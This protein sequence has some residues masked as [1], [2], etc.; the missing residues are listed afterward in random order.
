[1]LISIVTE[2]KDSQ[3]VASLVVTDAITKEVANVPLTPA[4]LSQL[5]DRSKEVYIEVVTYV[6]TDNEV[7]KK[8]IEQI[9]LAQL[10]ELPTIQKT[11]V[12]L[13]ETGSITQRH[14]EELDARIENR[15]TETPLTE[16][17][18][19]ARPTPDEPTVIPEP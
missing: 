12:S 11:I 13:V 3:K 8:L 4:Q 1:M 9:Q 19:E 18:P 10:T 5:S 7:Y 16:L 2:V 6:D 15:L 14:L 17:Q